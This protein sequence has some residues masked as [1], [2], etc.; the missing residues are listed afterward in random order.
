MD[1]DPEAEHDTQFSTKCLDFQINE[2][3]YFCSKNREEIQK[4]GK[5]LRKM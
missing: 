1:S 5:I 3:L 2:K 4:R